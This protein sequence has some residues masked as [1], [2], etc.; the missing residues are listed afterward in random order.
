[1][2]T[3]AQPRTLTRSAQIQ[4]TYTTLFI[5]IYLNITFLSVP[6][7][8]KQFPSVRLSDHNDTDDFSSLGLGTIFSSTTDLFA[9]IIVSAES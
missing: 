7:T 9:L 3:G 6:M 1:V 2:F 4:S 8:L 5:K